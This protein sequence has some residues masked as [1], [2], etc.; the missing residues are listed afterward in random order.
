MVLDEEYRADRIMRGFGSPNQ[1]LKGER[2]H[3]NAKN[4]L[5]TETDSHMGAVIEMYGV[6]SSHTTGIDVCEIQA[7]IIL[8]DRQV[9][10]RPRKQKLKAWLVSV[11]MNRGFRA[12]EAWLDQSVDEYVFH[13]AVVDERGWP[14]DSESHK[15]IDGSTDEWKWLLSYVL[16]QSID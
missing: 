15:T 12:L 8:L 5:V 1:N 9:V 11:Q 7:L 3:W 10:L 4:W 6:D 13:F 14:R 2:Q 16:A